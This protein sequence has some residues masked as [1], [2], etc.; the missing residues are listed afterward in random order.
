MSTISQLRF[1]HDSG[2]T[3][4]C[5]EV[6]GFGNQLPSADLIISD[7]VNTPKGSLFSRLKLKQPYTSLM[8]CS[9]LEM[10]VDM[11]N[12]ADVV[13]YGWVDS[14]TVESDTQGFPMTVV[15]WHP[16]YWRTY[17]SQ[18]EFGS[19][20]VRRRPMV[21]DDDLP[22][23]GYPY[24]YMVMDGFQVAVIPSIWWVVFTT[25]TSGE[26]SESIWGCFPINKDSPSSQLLIGA[27][28]SVPSLDEL[29][30]GKMDELLGLNP[31][32]IVYAFLSPISPR[33]FNGTGATNSPITMG[34]WSVHTNASAQCGYFIASGAEPFG[35]THDVGI[36]SLM[37][38]DETIYQ[39][40]GFQ[41][42][43]VGTLPWGIEVTR[44]RIRIVADSTSAYISLQFYSGSSADFDPLKSQ[45]EGTVF[46]I[47]CI[48]L[49]VTSNAWSSYVYS[50]SRQAE[51]DQRRL[52]AESQA[53]SGGISTGT[54]AVTGAVSGALMGGMAGAVG[55]PI[56]MVAGA[57]I[58][59]VGSAL[60]GALTTGAQYAYQTGAYAD[61]M[62]SISDYKASNQ[63]NSLILNGGTFDS[64]FNGIEG[65]QMVRMKKDAY[66]LQQRE[67]DIAIYGA[68]VSEPM[69]SCQ[70]LIEANGPLQIQNLTVRGNIP[71]E[72]KAMFRTRFAKGV[73]MIGASSN[74]HTI[75]GTT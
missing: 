53:V 11:N 22:P 57:L 17:L 75:G 13:I 62:Q 48:P 63:P 60:G 25:V 45:S 69:E 28:T 64:L 68:N 23:Q 8:T 29:G 49:P 12:G 19:G 7:E 46:N 44:L 2:F 67:N 34:G 14:V 31:E 33:T 40:N 16:D 39:V 41:G 43:A 56:G 54:S 20:M 4:G 3:D 55:G 5:L 32:S 1:W 50:G 70:E 35:V 15:D 52:Q 27:N 72:A 37:T 24:R 21:E 9:Y 51:M 36:G 59:G 18:A 38:D 74:A 30:S 61:E 73:R 10:T 71:V 58:G 65:I 6:P 42:E 66:S 47:P 26:T